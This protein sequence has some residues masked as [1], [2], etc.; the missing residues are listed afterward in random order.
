MNNNELSTIYIPENHKKYDVLSTCKKYNFEMIISDNNLLH[1]IEQLTCITDYMGLHPYQRFKSYKE[2]FDEID[3]LI[4]KFPTYEQKI[5]QY[6]NSVIK[7]NNKDLWAIVEYIGESNRNFTK[8]KYYY[9]VM[10][11]ESNYWTLRG[12]IDN[13]EYDTFLVWDPNSTNPIN[14]N[15]DFRIII[16]PSNTL[17]NEFTKI[18]QS[19]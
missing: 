9:V 3:S 11:V 7:M 12:I 10:Y 14:L 15:K 5:I 17:K 1:E 8:N 16:D 6:K 2:F 19:T 13:E 18:M 4:S